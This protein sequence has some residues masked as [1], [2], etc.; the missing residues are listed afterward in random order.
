[1]GTMDFME[2][3]TDIGFVVVTIIGSVAALFFV[4]VRSRRKNR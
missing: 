3:L 1:M 2:N 4:G